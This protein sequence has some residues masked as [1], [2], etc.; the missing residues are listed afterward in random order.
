MSAFMAGS[1][2]IGDAG[3]KAGDAENARGRAM[4]VLEPRGLSPS[5]LTPWAESFSPVRFVE[6]LKPDTFP[7]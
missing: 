4:I 5:R 3:S 2:D 7:L 1:L 6:S